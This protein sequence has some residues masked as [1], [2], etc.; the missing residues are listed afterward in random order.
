MRLHT[1]ALVGVIAAA[2]VISA[3][4]AEEY[5]LVITNGRVMDPETMYDSIANVG[6]SA[7]RI[8]V[9]TQDKI[10]GKQAIDATG[11]VVAPGFIDTHWHYDRPWSNKLALRDGRTSVMDLEVGT[12]GPYIDQWY[13]SRAGSNQVNYGQA[14]AHELARSTVLGG[15]PKHPS[16]S[17]G[18]A[19]I[20]CST[21]PR[22]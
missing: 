13:R 7:G 4:S 9:I 5:D 12:N 6:I 8:A 10:S 11:H 16:P 1:R 14:V 21:T 15:F 17:G 22:R 2:V 3:S 19:P 18:S 20:G